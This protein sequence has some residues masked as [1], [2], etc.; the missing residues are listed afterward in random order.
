LFIDEAYSL[1]P[2]DDNRDSYGREAI[3]TLLKLMEDHRDRLIVIVAGYTRL[4]AA[5]L[6]SNPGL[7]S[8][9]SRFFT[10]RD[11]TADELYEVFN[12]MV[13]KNGYE[14]SPAGAFAARALLADEYARKGASFGNARAVPNIFEQVQMRQADRL[15]ND[16]DIT[17]AELLTIEESDL[18]A[19][20]VAQ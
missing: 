13:G 17:R 18:Q 8:R 4:L 16:P 3:E 6:D 5:F 7:R 9:F 14:L 11:Y 2:L 19:V 10:F 12:R 20:E 1:A 15:A